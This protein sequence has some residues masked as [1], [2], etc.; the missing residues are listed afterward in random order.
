MPCEHNAVSER[1]RE[2]TGLVLLGFDLLGEGEVQLACSPGNSSACRVPPPVREQAS[3][4]RGQQPRRRWLTAS[5]AMPLTSLVPAS[6]QHE[7][8]PSA[9]CRCGGHGPLRQR[10]HSEAPCGAS[11]GRRGENG[12]ADQWRRDRRPDAA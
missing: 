7:D 10:A 2:I 11:G 1:P 12:S 8:K 4:M 3:S 9:S 5:E 6:E